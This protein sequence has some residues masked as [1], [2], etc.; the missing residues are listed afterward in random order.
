MLVS[1]SA[2]LD[3]LAIFLAMILGK[4]PVV[5]A[6]APTGTRQGTYPLTFATATIADA[7][8]DKMIPSP[9]ELNRDHSEVA[10]D[11]FEEILY[12]NIS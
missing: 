12:L 1:T 4:K 11:H 5:S 7:E 3:N 6:A 8:A 9:L 10:E 2:A